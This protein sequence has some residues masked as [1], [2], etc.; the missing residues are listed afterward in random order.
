M[1]LILIIVQA[2][3]EI[4]KVVLALAHQE[5]T[6]L[7]DKIFVPSAIIN[8][9]PAEILLILV[10]HAMILEKLIQIVNAQ[11][12]I[13]K[14]QILLVNNANGFALNVL[15]LIHALVVKEIELCQLVLAHLE[16]GM[17]EELNYAN[18]AITNVVLVKSK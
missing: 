4:D 1:F 12:D 13:I 2:A 9:K 3:A 11:L 14:L 16:H 10:L 17:M 15:I 7:L 8:A 5:P 18:Y 6:V